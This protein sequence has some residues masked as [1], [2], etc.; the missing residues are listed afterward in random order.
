MGLIAMTLLSFIV[1]T[2]TTTEIPTLDNN[3]V[4]RTVNASIS[5]GPNP[6]D[7]V[8]DIESLTYP[9]KAQVIREMIADEFEDSDPFV[10]QAVTLFGPKVILTCERKGYT[11][12]GERMAQLLLESSKVVK[13]ERVWS[14]LTL[15]YNNFGGVK[16]HKG[17][18]A[19]PALKTEEVFHGKRGVYKLKFAKFDTKWDGM[20]RYLKI[21]GNERYKK[22]MRLNG[23]GH[24]VALA[25]AGYCTEPADS[26]ADK[27]MSLYE[28]YNLQKLNKILESWKSSSDS[29]SGQLVQASLH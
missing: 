15:F 4:I 19:T 11:T 28:R 9:Q 18:K 6:K 26:Y 24:F 3:N 25:K 1:K 2:T 29:G 10:K 13:G 16:A 14:N 17:A 22:A 12:P 20:E 7:Y 21:V 27:C 23:R 5:G 8:S